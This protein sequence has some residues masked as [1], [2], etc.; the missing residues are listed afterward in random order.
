M[1]RVEAMAALI[2]KFATGEGSVETPIPGVW[3]SRFDRPHAPRH[4]V[5]RALFCV[6][7]EG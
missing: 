2:G 4:V 6:V 3:V 5:D 1:E 7:A